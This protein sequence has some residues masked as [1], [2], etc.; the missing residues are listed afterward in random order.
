MI[1]RFIDSVEGL[2]SMNSSR[3][4][5]HMAKPS[6]LVR[7]AVCP[8]AT[9]APLTHVFA[10]VTRTYVQSSVIFGTSR[11]SVLMPRRP[12][13]FVRHATPVSPKAARPRGDAIKEAI[14]RLWRRSLYFF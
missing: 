3:S 1:V 6:P 11:S 9:N 7:S 5:Q 2:V 10:P 8:V 13:Q 12:W 14:D 4:R